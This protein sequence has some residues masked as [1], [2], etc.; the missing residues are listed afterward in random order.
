MLVVAS[1]SVKKPLLFLASLASD[2]RRR[3]V[4][5]LPNHPSFAVAEDSSSVTSS[6]GPGDLEKNAEMLRGLGFASLIVTP[7]NC[8][9][10]FSS[11]VNDTFRLGVGDRM[12]NGDDTACGFGGT[13]GASGAELRR[14]L[15]GRPK[16]N[17]EPRVAARSGTGRG[18]SDLPDPGYLDILVEGDLETGAELARGRSGDG[19][20]RPNNPSNGSLA[21]GLLGVTT[22]GG[23]VY[24]VG[25]FARCS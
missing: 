7:L 17:V 18:D 24:D 25:G 13:G 22:T 15:S 2:L 4:F 10:S 5:A 8:A 19:T 14:I 16:P 11:P 1:L 21:I 20:S 12:G 6:D 9:S 3:I 23:G